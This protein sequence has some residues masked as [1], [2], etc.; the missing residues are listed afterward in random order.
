[1]NTRCRRPEEDP[2][3]PS[4]TRVR[5][6]EQRPHLELLF[7][8]GVVGEVDEL[9]QAEGATLPDLGGQQEADGGQQLQLAA[10]DPAQAQKTVQV[11]HRQRED[12]V[13]TAELLTDLRR[14]GDGG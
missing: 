10:A 6:V 14:T 9:G 11:V 4:G 5:P 7:G 1:M 3:D 13:L 8:D 12:L 2:R